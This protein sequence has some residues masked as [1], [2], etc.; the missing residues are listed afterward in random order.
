METNAK[1][2][3]MNWN[4]FKKHVNSIHDV[5]FDADGVEEKFEGK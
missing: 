5:C 2:L 3:E 1:G 4:A